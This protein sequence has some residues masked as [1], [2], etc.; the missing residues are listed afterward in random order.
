MILPLFVRDSVELLYE[1]IDL[2]VGDSPRS[3][4]AK[5]C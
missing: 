1:G 2:G 5:L 4:D 3:P